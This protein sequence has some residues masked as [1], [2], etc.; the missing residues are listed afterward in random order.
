MAILTEHDHQKL[1][2]HYMVVN[3]ENRR[4]PYSYVFLQVGVPGV[5]RY[6]GLVRLA[7]REEFDVLE[8][9]FVADPFRLSRDVLPL[10]SRLRMYFRKQPTL[11][12]ITI[13]KISATI[14][15][16]FAQTMRFGNFAFGCFLR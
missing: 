8:G 6:A 10:H 7:G 12:R 9:M 2:I 1:A 4:H 16:R 13:L 15:F 11:F 3:D 5:T 14:R